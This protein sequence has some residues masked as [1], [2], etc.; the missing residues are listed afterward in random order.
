MRAGA[1]LGLATLS[2]RCAPASQHN[3][4]GARPQA[5]TEE[6]DGTAEIVPR[7]PPEVESSQSTGR[8]LGEHQ[9]LLSESN[10]TNVFPNGNM[11][12]VTAIRASS[13]H[14]ELVVV[15]GETTSPI[16][17]SLASQTGATLSGPG[18]LVQ[19]YAE[20][21]DTGPE[22]FVQLD[23]EGRELCRADVPHLSEQLGMSAGQL[24]YVSLF[25]GGAV[26]T[27]TTTGDVYTFS[28][29]RPGLLGT[30]GKDEVFEWEDGPVCSSRRRAGVLAGAYVVE[31]LSPDDRGYS[32][33]E[34]GVLRVFRS[35]PDSLQ[36][37]W[38]SRDPQQAWSANLSL[39][40]PLEL[41][42]DAAGNGW[43]AVFWLRALSGASS[44]QLVVVNRDGE[45]RRES[46]PLDWG[47]KPQVAVAGRGWAATLPSQLT[48]APPAERRQCWLE[49]G[50]FDASVLD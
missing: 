40:E 19:G 31:R 50:S 22:H 17:T 4:N 33:S 36:V 35:G 1:L 48:N 28:E 46:F 24:E 30:C 26:F 23:Q 8:A 38:F 6:M 39:P 10:C 9:W 11:R 16:V 45:E 7:R 34:H 21:G 27:T 13:G 44:A 25:E 29:C 42:E 20:P 41:V 32:A 5:A 14:V 2:W 37:A 18:L 3:I 15:E 43:G 12:Y 47:G 49:S